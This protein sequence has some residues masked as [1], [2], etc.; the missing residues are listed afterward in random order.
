MRSFRLNPPADPGDANALSSARR[1]LVVLSILISAVGLLIWNG[2]TF[3]MRLSMEQGGFGP[4]LKVASSALMLNVALI[5]FGWRRYADLQFEAERR[6]EGEKKA[7]T[8]ASTD[9]M[10]GL[11]NRKGFGDESHGLRARAQA[12]DE[13]LVIVSLQLHRFKTVN[14]RHGFDVGDALIR[15]IADAI[16]DCA[17]DN[18]LVARLSGDEFAVALALPETAIGEAT[19][20]GHH[21]L[22]SITR[23]FEEQGKFIQVGAFAGIATA[24]PG[25]GALPDLLR[26]ADIALAH[27]RSA[28]SA[29]PAW[30]DAGMER[31]LIAHSEIEQGIRF[32]LEHDQFVPVFEPQVDLNTGEIRSFEVLA[33]WEHPLTGAV[34]PDRFIPIAEEIGLI[35]RLSDQVVR[36]ALIAAAGWDAAI[37]L[38][39]NISPTQL[40]D[41]WLAQRIVRMLTETGFPPERLVVEITESSL[42]ADLE[43][44]RA[45][46]TSLKA[47]GIRLALDDFG[48][49]FSSLSHLRA[50]PFDMIKIDRSFVATLQTDRGSAAIIR[51]VA[52]LAQAL[53]VPVT[54]EG[55][56]DAETLDALLAI[57]CATGQ[58]WYFG[59]PMGAE[60]A[61]QLLRRR[62]PGDGFQTNRKS[63]AQ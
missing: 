5:L 39:I 23:P 3:F 33:R 10:T 34:T 35:G 25:D 4:G 22:Q 46:V 17:G 26:R 21:L 2:S 38:S 12:A 11:L 19:R 31:A 57:G 32:G 51:A 14:D 6:A 15:K 56:E 40:A 8:L 16:R 55:I 50:L 60:D 30:F 24:A 52:T 44:A 49:G 28:R 61:L 47:Q 63:A 13:Q 27:A 48:S 29:R 42:F 20:L 53:D 45:I 62:T 59:K 9:G 41:S 36:K 37:S 54:A 58:G 18:A 7:H 1:D 43:L